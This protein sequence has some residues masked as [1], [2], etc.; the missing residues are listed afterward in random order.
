MDRTPKY[1]IGW[2][3][4][5]TGI[6]AATLRVWE[7]RYGFPQP[8]RTGTRYRLFSDEEVLWIRWVQDR[9]AEG[10]SPRQAVW[11]AQR[12]REAALP[13]SSG[14]GV[15]LEAVKEELLA[16]LLAFDGSRA[17][18]L[19][20]AAHGAASAESVVRE[21]LLPAVAAV[22]AEWEAGRATV[23]QEH[24]ASHLALQHLAALLHGPV[25]SG[26]RL[27]CACA[28][29]EHHQLGLLYV[30]AAARLRGW[31]VI[32]LGADTPAADLLG[33][34]ERLRPQAVLVS[35]V[36]VDAADAWGPYRD[37]CRRLSRRGTAWLWG[38]P[39]ARTA[40]A[41]RLPGRVVTTL[42]EAVQA[43]EE[44]FSVTSREAG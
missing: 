17:E 43:L 1:T 29:G 14:S 15:S 26:P 2:V 11:L 28:P 4:R 23:S 39:A 38:G 5:S 21:V 30:A 25:P 35:C 42:E 6:R 13:P 22:G 19:L 3:A 33:L 7:R 32:Y 8:A 41:R 31:Q 27:V 44:R 20:R 18:G 37:L 34:A 36:N 24:F 10:I 12:R 9:I 40:R 16:A